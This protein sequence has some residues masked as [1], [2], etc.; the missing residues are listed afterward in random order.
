MVR[1]EGR[2]YL[3]IVKVRVE[4]E[5]GGKGAGVLFGRDEIKVFVLGGGG[6]RYPYI[7]QER[8]GGSLGRLSFCLSL[9]HITGWRSRGRGMRIW[10]GEECLAR[11]DTENARL[12]A[13]ARSATS[14]LDVGLRQWTKG[15]SDQEGERSVTKR[16]HRSIYCSLTGNIVNICS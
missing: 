8:Q 9:S 16:P 6:L 10:A 1:K 12:T 15:G 2:S 4:V 5:A 3:G 7:F 13:A 14:G 11:L